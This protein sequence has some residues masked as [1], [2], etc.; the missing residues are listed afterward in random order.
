[1][2]SRYRDGKIFNRK[3]RPYSYRYN[4]YVRGIVSELRID[5]GIAIIY[6]H[7][8]SALQRR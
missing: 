3:H 4:N 8:K 2:K 1:M 5:K 6:T 7:E